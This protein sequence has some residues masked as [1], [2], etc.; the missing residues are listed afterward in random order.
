[1][2]DWSWNLVANRIFPNFDENL[3]GDS[4]DICLIDKG[5]FNI[6]LSELRLTICA[7][8]FISE[9]ASNLVVTLH[10]CN[11]QELLEKLR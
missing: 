7:E 1:M 5:H 9:T 11:H 10:A 6:E 4:Q 3:F 8:I 2:L